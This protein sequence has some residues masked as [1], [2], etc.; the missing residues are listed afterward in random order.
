MPA[1]LDLPSVDAF[2]PYPAADVGCAETGP[3]AGC[4]LAVKDLFD[5]AGYPTGCG[6][7][8]VLAASGTKDK[9]APAVQTL[10]D[11]G[12]RF[13]GKTHTDELAWALYGV[14]PHFGTPR[15]PA[16][17][18]RIPGGSSS[19]SASAVAAGLADIGLGTDTGGSIRAPAS[20]CGLW[21]L[22]PTHGRISL[23]R[24]MELA[25]RF[26]TCGF[27]TRD[28]DLL[29]Q[30]AAVLLGEDRTPLPDAPRLVLAADMAARLGPSQRALF[31]RTF[32]GLEMAEANVYGAIGPDGL[33][34]AFRTLQAADARHFVVPLIARTGMPLGGGLDARYAFAM[35]LTDADVAKAD[36]VQTVFTSHMEGL[37]GSFSVLVAP[38]V[39]DA[40]FRRDAPPEI[41]ENFRHAAMTLLSVAGMAGLPQVVMPAGLIGGAPFGVS[42][43][44]PRG[45]DLSLIALAIRLAARG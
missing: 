44:G 29:A 37:L 34:Q 17:P 4:T 11:A 36:A 10:L 40:A 3:L 26:D 41:F 43:I 6:S 15:N 39:P 12:A 7:P 35:S 25:A 32:A 9:T 19:G 24:C 2:L 16:A 31:D 8:L 1:P 21:G 28:G 18:D 23:Y 33:Y 27:L 14:N 45:S 30:T 5:V 38:A 42:L 13:V 22:R 20:F